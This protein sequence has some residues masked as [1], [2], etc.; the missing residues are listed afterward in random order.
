MRSRHADVDPRDHHAGVLRK[1]PGIR[2]RTRCRQTGLRQLR[3]RSRANGQERAPRRRLL[4][5]RERQ[6]AG[7]PRRSLPTRVTTAR[8]SRCT[9]KP[10]PTCTP[11]STSLRRES[12]RP[13]ASTRRSRTC[14]PAGWTRP[15]SRRAGFEPVKPYLARI[16]A[17]KDKA[18]LMKL[19][20]TVDYQAPFSVFVEA[21]Y[22]GS[23]ALRGLGDA[24]PASACRTATTTSTRV[25]SSTPIAR[26][27]YLRHEDLRADRR[28]QSG[29][30]RASV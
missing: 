21:R 28:R 29:T 13:A 25:P 8:S 19:I 2:T 4:S 17:A 27:I 11:S 10:K 22:G 26:P 7:R 6:V 1:E 9:R 24:S 12:M 5:L 3:R 16:A 18:D 15:A 23:D 20:G 14:T 30:V